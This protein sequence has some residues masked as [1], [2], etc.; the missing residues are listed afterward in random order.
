MCCKTTGASIERGQWAAGGDGLQLAFISCVSCTEQVTPLQ[1][2]APAQTRPETP[3][4][5]PRKQVWANTT[6]LDIASAE[7]PKVQALA[8]YSG[9]LAGSATIS[10]RPLAWPGASQPA[11][12]R[13][14]S[15]VSDASCTP[16]PLSVPHNLV[17]SHADGMRNVKAARLTHRSCSMLRRGNDRQQ[18]GR[19]Q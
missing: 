14:I 2:R 13:A 7:C 8:H 6:Q 19:Q 10:R 12:A 17:C 11:G 1:G 9:L 15:V 4:K 5:L 3:D 16:P 18:A